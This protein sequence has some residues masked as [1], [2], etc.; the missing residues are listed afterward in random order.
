M[1]SEKNKLSLNWL[2]NCIVKGLYEYMVSFVLYFFILLFFE[3]DEKTEYIFYIFL[4][5]IV[6]ENLL[7]YFKCKKKKEAMI[8]LMTVFIITL[9]FF[10]FVINKNFI[11]ETRNFITSLKNSEFFPLNIIF[12]LIFGIIIIFDGISIL[13]DKIKKILVMSK[14]S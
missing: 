1:K 3:F 9:I 8:K 10:I 4:G 11:E 5:I 12:L 14:Q 6:I 7:K 13:M 2:L